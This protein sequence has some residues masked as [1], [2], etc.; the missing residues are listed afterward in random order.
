MSRLNVN[1]GLIALAL[2]TFAGLFAS[3]SGL[4]LILNANS[5]VYGGLLDYAFMVLGLII[6]F[7]GTHIF[8]AGVDSIITYIRRVRQ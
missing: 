7:I 2:L 1:K 4:I 8:L 3:I 5:K 6:L